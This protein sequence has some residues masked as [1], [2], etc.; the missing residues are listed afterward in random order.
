MKDVEKLA[1][2][3]VLQKQLKEN[4][5][6]RNPDSLRYRCDQALLEMYEEDGV[7]RKQ[8]K[9]NGEKV[10]TQSLTFTKPKDGIEPYIENY[11][12]FTRWLQT[13]AGYETLRHA[14]NTKPDLF[15]DYLEKT[16]EVGD[17]VSMREV[18]EPSR[19]KGTTVRVDLSKVVE[20]FG[21][22]L[23]NAIVGLLEGGK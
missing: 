14:V 11:E 10:G 8:I 7:D 19:V 2:A 18:H 4:L 5:D 21:K 6:Q 22:E 17:G 23:P 13:E 3:T 16:G 9:V 15:S 20:A 1:I 12:A